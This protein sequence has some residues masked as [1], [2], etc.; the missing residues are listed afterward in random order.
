MVAMLGGVSEVRDPGGGSVAIHDF[1]LHLDDGRTIAVE[2]TRSNVEAELQQQ[3]EVARSD[4]HFTGLRF[5]WHL[6]MG[7]RFDV[8]TI[9]AEAPAL[10][11]A[12]EESGVE[13]VGVPEKGSTPE[14]P[15]VRALRSIGV[16]LLYRLNE[17]SS[18]GGTVDIGAGPVTGATAPHMAVEVAEQ[19]AERKGKAAKLAASAAAERHLFV[20]V[21]S[22]RHAAV[23]AIRGGELPERA[24]E[25]PNGIDVV[26]LAV[27]YEHPDVW[28]F[29]RRSGWSSWGTPT[30]TRAT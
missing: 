15:T 22:S 26:W 29:D 12:L 7:S 19:A 9:R 21:E 25:L 3:A 20:W 6:G 13:A 30:R 1:D 11:A 5:N 17:A 14:G 18:A 28:Q 27:A 4:P 23:A 16:R 24:P 2:V 10:L 8:R